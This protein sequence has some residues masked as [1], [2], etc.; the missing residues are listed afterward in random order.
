[1]T[2]RAELPYSEE[3]PLKG[4]MEWLFRSFRNLSLWTDTVQGEL[5]YGGLIQRA[6]VA[7]PDITSPN[8]A[9]VPFDEGL[10]SDPYL[11]FQD[12]DN[13]LFQV[14]AEGLWFISSYGSFL[15]D[16]LASADRQMYV[17]FYTIPDATPISA[18]PFPRWFK[19]RLPIKRCRSKF[20]PY[21][22]PACRL[23]R[24]R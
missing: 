8:Y 19:H 2:W 5:G 17:R 23:S 18:N 20:R 15:V 10:V 6:S 16:K 9:T 13:D 4:R 14:E 7:I 1:M 22:T 11:V 24:S 12:P 3:T 21:G